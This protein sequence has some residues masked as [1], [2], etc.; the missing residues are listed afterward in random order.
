MGIEQ[1]SCAGEIGEFTCYAH[2]R[3]HATD[4]GSEYASVWMWPLVDPCNDF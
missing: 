4:N 1:S 2:S 3:L